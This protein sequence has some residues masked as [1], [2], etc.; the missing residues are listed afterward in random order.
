MR[1][2]AAARRALRPLRSRAASHWD[3]LPGTRSG[4]PFP[5]VALCR[6]MDVG[7]DVTG[8]KALQPGTYLIRWRVRS[9]R[10]KAGMRPP[11][12]LTAMATTAS[13][14]KRASA[15][16]S[17][18]STAASTAA[19]LAA[20]LAAITA[21]GVAGP[22]VLGVGIAASV[23]AGGAVA[24]SVA[25]NAMGA[26][27][28]VPCLLLPAPNPMFDTQ[29][30]QQAAAALVEAR[31]RGPLGDTVQNQP[32]R[33]SDVP[34]ATL[35]GVEGTWRL[36]LEGHLTGWR[37]VHVAIAQVGSPCLVKVGI[38][39]AR[40]PGTVSGLAIDYVEFV[41]LHDDAFRLDG[42]VEP[43]D[44]PEPALVDYDVARQLEAM[45]L[46]RGAL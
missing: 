19:G 28:D 2:V 6:S 16:V 13:L 26:A 34:S 11:L 39:G 12:T 27:P 45:T 35:F 14:Q 15:A 31:S 21:V 3:L 30:A 46:E 23:A 10:A 24:A 7:F 32:A 43:V 22:I 36:D 8:S 18:T 33:A 40:H 4:S 29:A 25:H 1:H 5:T 17:A 44:V 42:A 41:P 20:T 9:A 37:Y 38:S